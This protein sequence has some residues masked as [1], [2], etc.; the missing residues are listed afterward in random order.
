MTLALT[1]FE[2]AAVERGQQL[3]ANILM[4]S[5]R[6]RGVLQVLCELGGFA[7]AAAV[8]QTELKALAER[9]RCAGRDTGGFIS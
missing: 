1:P 2:Q 3:S 7:S 4:E 6:L 8:A 9:E 5:A